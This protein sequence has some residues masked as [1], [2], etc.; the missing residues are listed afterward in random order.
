MVP[1][2]TISGRIFDADGEPLGH[3]LVMQVNLTYKDGRRILIATQHQLTDERGRYRLF[4]VRPGRVY[5]AAKVEELSEMFKPGLYMREL[6]GTPVVTRRTLP[7]GEVIE[8]TDGLVYYGGAVDAEQARPIDVGPGSDLSSIDISL[9]PGKIRSHHI[10]GV[11]INGVTRQPAAGIQVRAVPT[12]Q[13]PFNAIPFAVTDRNGAFDLPGAVPG[14]YAVFSVPFAAQA[15]Q[16]GIPA[17]GIFELPFGPNAIP[18]SI[19]KFVSI[20]QVRVEMPDADIENLQIIAERP[21]NLAGRIVIKGG[22]NVDF[23]K[24]QVALTW[25]PDV[26]GMPNT[27]NFGVPAA[28]S[29][30]Q[31]DGSFALIPSSGHYQLAVRGIPANT[32]V[33]SARLGSTDILS[34]GLRLDGP[35][36]SPLNIVVADNAGEL[37]GVAINGRLATMPNVVVALVPE[38]PLRGRHDLYATARTDIAGRFHLRT[39]PPGDY[40]LFAWEHAEPDSWHDARFLQPYEA[41]GTPIRVTEGSNPEARVTVIPIRK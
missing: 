39:I 31:P 28:T 8:E 41:Y 35:P 5:V 14:S 2:G 9:K 23:K 22:A 26:L 6:A 32:F 19:A 13:S 10:R 33:E 16:N 38:S 37:N 25:D 15:V 4:G 18:S 7:D 34:G 12:K 1:N 11:L 24:I 27:G 30:V 17:N 20:G 29:A 21:S 40:K 3:A 36:D